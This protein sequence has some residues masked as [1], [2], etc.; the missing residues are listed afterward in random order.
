MPGCDP[1]MPI[2]VDPREASRQ[3]CGV[4]VNYACSRLTACIFQ[5]EMRGPLAA[6]LAVVGPA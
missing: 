6:I 4:R 2:R 1:A 5:R 3:L